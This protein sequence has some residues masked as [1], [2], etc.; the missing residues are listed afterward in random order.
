MIKS[1]LAALAIVSAFALISP[2]G[3]VGAAQAW[4]VSG[5]ESGQ[6]EGCAEEYP[7]M[8][9]EPGSGSGKVGGGDLPALTE[10]QRVALMAQTCN[11]ALQNLTKIPASMVSSF[12]ADNGVSVVGVCDTGLGHKA[13]I[14]A[15]QALPLQAAIAA[16][17]VL[18]DALRARGYSADDVV[19]VVIVDGAATLYAHKSA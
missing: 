4:S 1:T 17:P 7:P 10:A 9:D 3:F 15:S 5:C 13:V 16:N 19:G 8:P 2:A 11:T 6:G 18:I 12:A 14:D